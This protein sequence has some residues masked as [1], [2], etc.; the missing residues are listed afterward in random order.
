MNC[1]FC[2]MRDGSIEV[3]KIDENPYAFAIYD[4]HPAAKSHVLV[5]PKKHCK[6]ILE[7]NQNGDCA[8]TYLGIFQLVEGVVKK[9]GIS[10][11]G[12]RLVVN[13]GPDASQSVFHL[14]FHVLGGQKLQ[15]S[16]N[17]V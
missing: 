13:A 1:L 4:I 11:S 5:I 10:E 7:L 16:V 14:H 2:G 12:F 15:A 17:P 9:T 8:D 6:D 3:K